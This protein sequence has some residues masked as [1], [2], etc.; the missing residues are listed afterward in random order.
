[1]TGFQVFTGLLE[2]PVLGRE[3]GREL[4]TPGSEREDFG[5]VDLLG[6]LL[7]FLSDLCFCRH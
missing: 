4:P 1:M 6:F 2:S 7:L 5:G 3:L